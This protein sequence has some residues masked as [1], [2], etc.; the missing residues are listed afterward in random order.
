MAS[1]LWYKKL[2]MA[3]GTA[4]AEPEAIRP[5]DDIYCKIAATPP[6]A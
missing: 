3:V 1:L 5:H 6:A 4:A 2:I